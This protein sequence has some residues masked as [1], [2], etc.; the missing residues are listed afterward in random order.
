[1]RLVC[2]TND[3]MRKYTELCE[4]R[5]LGFEPWPSRLSVMVAEGKELVA[6]VMVYDSTGPFL[7]FEHLVTNETASLRQRYHAADILVGE[8][9]R[10]CRLMGKVPMVQV[11]H[12]G[13]KRIL[14]KHGLVAP[15]AFFMTCHFSN[16]ETHDNEESLATTKHPRRLKDSAPTERAPLGDPEDDLG[17][18]AQVLG[19]AAAPAGG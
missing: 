15:G 7:F 4:D 10:M 5:G 8:C 6:G 13:I 18:Y 3:W 12:K 1:M 11:R 14:E 9:V 2:A 16:L 17:V 19:G